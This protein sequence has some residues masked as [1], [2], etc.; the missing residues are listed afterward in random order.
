[1]LSLNK[2]DKIILTF[3]LVGPRVKNMLGVGTSQAKG[4][5]LLLDRWIIV[6]RSKSNTSIVLA[7][8]PCICSFATI[9]G[10]L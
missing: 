6:L 8:Q 10:S 7:L 2:T 9:S 3:R 5:Y 1:M 4:R